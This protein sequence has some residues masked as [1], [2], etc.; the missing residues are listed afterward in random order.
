MR[1]FGTLYPS[2]ISV[3]G[4]QNCRTMLHSYLGFLSCNF[5]RQKLIGLGSFEFFFF[6][7]ELFHLFCLGEARSSLFT[8][9]RLLLPFSPQFLN[10][11]WSAIQALP[12]RYLMEAI[13]ACLYLL[14]LL[15][16]CTDGCFCFSLSLLLCASCYCK[17]DFPILL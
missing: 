16:F 10:R 12:R 3:R 15:L 5:W 1:V 2:L 6:F 17:L 11:G 9:S 14:L 4:L 13:T 7:F 8:F